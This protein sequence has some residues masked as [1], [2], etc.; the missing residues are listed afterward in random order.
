M[1]FVQK[2]QFIPLPLRGFHYMGNRTEPVMRPAAARA[3][4][5]VVKI[6]VVFKF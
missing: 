3:A 1:M 6:V 2:S 5:K 4:V